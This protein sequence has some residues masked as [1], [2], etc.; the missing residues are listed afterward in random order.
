MNELKMISKIVELREEAKHFMNAFY[1][2]ADTSM[3]IYAEQLEDDALRLE[4]EV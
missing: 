4:L 2:T 1:I 3:L